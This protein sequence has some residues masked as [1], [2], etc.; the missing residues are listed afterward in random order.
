MP[1]IR[2]LLIDDDR[3]QWELVREMLDVVAPAGYEV[4][5]A[6]TYEDGLRR[7]RDDSIDVALVDY[8]LGASNGLDLIRA[9]VR[10]LRMETPLIM[11]TGY[12][13]RALDLQAMESGAA[14][15]LSKPDLSPDLLDR[16]LR[17]AVRHAHAIRMLRENEERFRALI[18]NTWDAILVLDRDAIVTFASESSRLVSG[19]APRDI[20][21]HDFFRLIHPDDRPLLG[22]RLEETMS[23]ERGARI[24]AECRWHHRDGTWRDSE[25]IA[26]NRLDDPA[27]RGIVINYRDVSER[28]RAAAEKQHLAA[29]VQ[30]SQDAIVG[31]RLDGTI[32]SW[33]A[34]AEALFH[35]PAGEMMGRSIDILIPADRSQERTDVIAR[36]RQGKTIAPFDTVRVRADGARIPV[37]LAISPVRNAVGAIVGASSVARDV[38]EQCAAQAAALETAR[39]YRALFDAS[40]IGLA[41]LD[42]AG[43]WVRVNRRLCEMLKYP[44]EELHGEPAAA[45]LHPEDRAA[46][47][48]AK[49]KLLEGT[50]A[51]SE[52]EQRFRRRD[53][54][55]IWVRSHAEIHRGA[56]EEPRYFIGAFQ[57]VS[58]RKAAEE[59][60]RRTVHQL[61]AVVSA[62]PMSLWA[63]DANGVITFAEGRLLER[64]GL[65]PGELIGRSQFEMYYDQPEILQWTRRALTGEQVHFTLPF[66]GGVFETWYLPLFDERHTVTGAIGVT[67]EITDRLRLEEQFRQAQKME[68]VGRL[69][70]GVAHDFNN[71]LTAILGY[72]ELALSALPAASDVRGDIEEILKAGQ[73]AASLTRQL[74]A[75][76]RRQIVQPQIVGLNDVIVRTHGLLRRVIGEDITLTLDLAPDTSRVF[77]D[78]SQ[79]EQIVMNLAVNARDAMPGG[80]RLTI[81]T[82]NIPPAEHAGAAESSRVVLAVSDT[83]TGIPPEVQR[84]LFEPFFTTK[85]RGKGTG[86]GL[87]TVYAIVTQSQGSIEVHSE[88]GRGTTFEILLP[89]AAAEGA[90]AAAAADEPP[91]SLVGNETILLVEDQEEV[92]AVARNVLRR[93]GYVVIEAAGPEEALGISGNRDLQIDLLLTDIVLPVMSGRMLATK[94]RT[95]RPALKVLYTSGYSDPQGLPQTTSDGTLPFVQKPF[96][97]V[98]LLSKVREVLDERGGNRS[99]M[100]A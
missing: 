3:Q 72:G 86:L 4:L 52:M 75:F 21:G 35:Y 40:P 56:D 17:Y 55:Y 8:A 31:W 36:V 82:R 28:Q 2:V 97:P 70:G 66:A 43:R 59:Q 74:L 87:A 33:N 88:P 77:A 48:Q 65:E 81:H 53:G 71:L 58:A 26:V 94:I 30:S 57:D 22:A 14:E 1:A 11:L 16:T 50:L 61:Q 37:S 10:S 12:G 80:G 96:T 85:E 44:E 25:L 27:V 89:A 91:A 9:A 99:S 84:R 98:V 29:I 19:F 5:W 47:A 73:S 46:S 83:G 42:L 90:A 51:R 60:L 18:Q 39:E 34:G 38:S 13:D 54:S 24:V 41:H 78:P 92:R 63:V 62:V 32:V 93:S 49:N 69:A 20:V 68:A 95:D 45:L 23:G 64:F 67:M 7:L 79:L 6:S 76:S 15:Y 100:I